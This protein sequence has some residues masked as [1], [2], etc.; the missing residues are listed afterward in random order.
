M[1][2]IYSSG[3]NINLYCLV[4]L[5]MGY[6]YIFTKVIVYY[7]PKQKENEKKMTISLLSL[8]RTQDGS[9]PRYERRL[10]AKRNKVSIHL[11]GICELTTVPLCD[12]GKKL[13][14]KRDPNPDLM[15]LIVQLGKQTL[16]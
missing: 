1:L 16:A 5:L 3:I 15:Q 9:S 10:L 14:S 13:M 6:L 8:P 11:L 4:S 12:T 2:I 7:I